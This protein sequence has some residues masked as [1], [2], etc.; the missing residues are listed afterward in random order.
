M[1][2]LFFLQPYWTHLH[3]YVRVS[4]PRRGLP[5]IRVGQT[6]RIAR[7][8]EAPCLRRCLRWPG[9]RHNVEMCAG[10]GDILRRT[11]HQP[12]DSLP[13]RARDSP[14]EVTIGIPHTATGSPHVCLQ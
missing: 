2:F 3:L 13:R 6:G 4:P 12:R 8:L 9:P 10:V 5:R 11:I 1:C 14:I 7:R